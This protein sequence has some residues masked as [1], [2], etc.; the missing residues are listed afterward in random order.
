MFWGV[1]ATSS[2]RYFQLSVDSNLFT[3]LYHWSAKLAH[4]LP[5]SSP[6]GARSI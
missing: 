4:D 3:S 5:L 2:Q 1:F 6:G